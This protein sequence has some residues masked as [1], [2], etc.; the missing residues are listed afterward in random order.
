MIYNIMFNY[1]YMSRCRRCVIDYL[2]GYD[3]SPCYCCDLKM[4]RIN[5][6]VVCFETIQTKRQICDYCQYRP[7]KP[8]TDRKLVARGLKGKYNDIIKTE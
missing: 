1:C 2:N 5:V 6:C 4:R 8:I 3:H 7:T